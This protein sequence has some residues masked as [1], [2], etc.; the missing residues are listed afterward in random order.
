VDYA[1]VK[2]VHQSAVA[3]SFAGFFARGVGM[4]GGAPWVRRPLAKTVPHIVD[5][6]LLASALALVWMLQAS[7]TAPWLM[8]KIAGLVVYIVLGAI[9]LRGGRTRGV[10]IAAWLAAMA[11]FGYIVSVAITKNPLG[12]VALFRV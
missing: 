2:L 12:I 9:A 10:R 4:I 8:A 3:L 6:V 7:L 1:L 5:T 11:T